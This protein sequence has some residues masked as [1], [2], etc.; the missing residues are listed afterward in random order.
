MA[1][2]SPEIFIKDFSPPE[3]AMYFL[4]SAKKPTSASN[5]IPRENRPC[6][7]CSHFIPPSFIT[8]PASI[9]T[10][11]VND[12]I[13]IVVD[14]FFKNDL[15]DVLRVSP[16]SLIVSTMFLPVSLSFSAASPAPS[17]SF[18]PILA[19]TPLTATISNNNNRMAP[20][21]PTA[22]WSFSSGTSDSN[23]NEAAIR[24]MPSAALNNA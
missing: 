10:A 5:I 23:I 18:L 21:A 1:V 13:N 19:R 11:V 16:N 9:A 8:T 3:T 7:I 17:S 4:I 22:A 24:A 14:A 20:R 2:I 15:M 12:A 6:Q